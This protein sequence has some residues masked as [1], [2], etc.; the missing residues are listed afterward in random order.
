MSK[1]SYAKITELTPEIYKGYHKYKVELEIPK[2]LPVKKLI[3]LCGVENEFTIDSDYEQLLYLYLSR[4]E[5]LDAEFYEEIKQVKNYKP[6]S[7]LLAFI[8]VLE[9]NKPNPLMFRFYLIAEEELD[10]DDLKQSITDKILSDFNPE[11]LATFVH[12]SKL[13]Y[14]PCE[15]KHIK[16]TK[17]P[18]DPL[19]KK[20]AKE[21][22][23]NDKT[24]G[25]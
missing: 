4:I 21:A 20:M 7:E 25:E 14:L 1:E 23:I 6:T 16:T 11:F 13:R 3:D 2:K 10:Q 12:I 5:G 24:N 18:L 19:I 8:N 22:G 17:I 15:H 9:V